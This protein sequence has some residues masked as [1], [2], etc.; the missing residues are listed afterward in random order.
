MD[1]TAAELTNQLPA[2]K[3]PDCDCEGFVRNPL[4]STDCYECHH[5]FL[6]HRRAASV[7]KRS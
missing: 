5:D 1:E 2:C 6:R 4:V 7:K 3:E